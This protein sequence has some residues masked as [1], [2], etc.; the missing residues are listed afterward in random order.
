M[1]STIQQLFDL[2]GKTAIVT[3]GAMG[4]GKGIA[5]RLAQAGASVMIVDIVSEQEAAPTIA[6][7]K[8]IG[9]GIAYLQVDLSHAD[10]LMLVIEK[11]LEIFGDIHILVN[12]AGIFRYTPIT[13]L[14]E[15]IWDKTLNL[16]LKA[17]AFLSK[18][19][20][21]TLIAKKPQR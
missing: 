12:N 11:T 10:Q 21:N 17:V 13:D 3:G 2:S 18:Y 14:T 6:Q 5:T 16:N 9:T 8:S 20:I 19:F 7:L 1:N 4:I 15:E